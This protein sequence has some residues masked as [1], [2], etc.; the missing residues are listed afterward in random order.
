MV[1]AAVAL[2]LTTL[3]LNFPEALL[4]TIAVVMFWC[5]Y[6]IASGKPRL[7]PMLLLLYLVIIP[8]VALDSP[9]GAFF[10]A[11]ALVQSFVMAI[12]IVWTVYLFWPAIKLPATNAAVAQSATLPSPATAAL[13]STAVLLPLMLLFL[14]FSLSYALPVLV[15]TLLVLSRLTMTSSQQHA[16]A[17]LAGNLEGGI[18]GLIIYVLLAVAPS[19]VTLTLLMMLAGL[20]FGTRITAGGTRAVMAFIACNT[21]VIVLS[22]S[23][24]QG[25][26]TLQLWITRLFYIFAAAAF[27][28]GMMSLLWP[29]TKQQKN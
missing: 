5:F 25:Q 4:G 17:L 19:L 27:S 6:L 28:V 7:L 8:V 14:V 26:G 13:L 1:A 23:L 24:L 10:I 16:M 9:S 15:S 22:S 20:W 3:F 11:I 2:T 29:S 12:F 18:V 21:M